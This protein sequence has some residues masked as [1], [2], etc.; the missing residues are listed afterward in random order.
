M[1]KSAREKRAW[2]ILACLLVGVFTIGSTFL[3]CFPDS[4]T[5]LVSFVEK[6]I[7]FPW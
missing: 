6:R 5:K 2:I 4:I 1:N 3:I 7:L